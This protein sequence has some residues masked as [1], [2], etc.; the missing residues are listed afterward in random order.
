MDFRFFGLVLLICIRVS[1]QTVPRDSISLHFTRDSLVASPG[2]TISSRL[3]LRNHSEKQITIS[4]KWTHS[5][6]LENISKL[7]AQ[8]TLP[9]HAETGLPVKFLV[10]MSPRSGNQQLSVRINT[11]SGM[12]ETACR[13]RISDPSPA[14]LIST[15]QD[16]P[17][18][19]HPTEGLR[20]SVRL[21]NQT[22]QSRKIQLE[23]G[24]FP[25][26]FELP[27]SG[28]RLLVPARTDT[29]LV[30]TCQTNRYVN[31]QANYLLTLTLKDSTG[32][33]IGSLLFKPFFQTSER[34][35]AAS[36]PT[37]NLFP[38]AIQAGF[39]RLGPDVT[40]R[41]IRLWGQENSERSIIRYQAQYLNSTPGSRNE[42]RDAFVEVRKK[43]TTFRVGNLYDYQELALLGR[44][45]HIGKGLP[46]GRLD[47]RVLDNNWNLLHSF[48][49]TSNLTTYSLQWQ[50]YTGKSKRL[51]LGLS[52]NYQYNRRFQNGLLY[53]TADFQPNRYHLFHL[54][55][56]GSNTWSAD[57]RYA[58]SGYAAGISYTLDHP[59]IEFRNR[60]YYSTPGYAGFQK[61]ARNI[62]SWLIARKSFRNRFALHLNTFRYE[63]AARPEILRYGMTIAE[64]IY[65]HT[66]NHWIFTLKPYYF[67]QI[68]GDSAAVRSDAYRLASSVAFQGK[69]V[70]VELGYDP[71]RYTGAAGTFFSQRLNLVLSSPVFGLYALYQRGPYFLTDVAE[72]PADFRLFSTTPSVH[73]NGKT[74]KGYIGIN[75]TF[76]S[77]MDGWTTQLVGQM[78]VRVT[79]DLFLLGEAAAFSRDA[80]LFRQP[81]TVLTSGPQYR[82]SVQKRLR[83]FRKPPGRT[84]RLRFFEDLNQNGLHDSDEP[85][86]PKLVVRIDGSTLVTDEKGAIV[87]KGLPQ[88]SYDIQAYGT[89][90]SGNPAMYS[91][92]ITLTRSVSREIPLRR[93]IRISGILRAPEQKYLQ[94]ST[95]FS[96]FKLL[97]SDATGTGYPGYPDRDGRFAL[98]L[99]AGSYRVDVLDLRRT[100]S[101]AV[102]HSQQLTVE[103][104]KEPASFDI[105]LEHLH[106]SIEVRRLQSRL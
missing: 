48:R 38:N 25:A 87:F 99:P 106:R 82:L 56:G 79:D 101:E 89:F 7:P 10:I 33:H 75:A 98:F 39:A 85:G 15:E 97:A 34:R 29:T 58:R 74:V 52:P 105:L 60:L 30:V 59:A 54:V 17:A 64:G 42:L 3:L 77:R 11:P 91:E 24:S 81:E 22:F 51:L 31:M 63:D 73:F 13:I 55:L 95:D 43:S 88:G 19:L 78:T 44:G 62:D 9:P 20:L 23:L 36:D 65:T 35:F 41:E 67:G 16:Q 5:S 61:G 18:F 1:G 40:N 21:R 96:Q 49:D 26:G 27:S 93:T 57:R 69:Q 47:F 37:G 53:T 72:N 83:S 12:V 4:V 46:A 86:L 90:Q 104:R 32:Q 8:L 6:D 66:G 84:L 76:D 70:R 102:V 14:W 94:Q 68:G 28:S 50:G 2:T 100:A 92:R 45:V 80:T 71:G 103:S